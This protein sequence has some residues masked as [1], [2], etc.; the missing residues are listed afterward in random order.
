LTGVINRII[1][2]RLNKHSKIFVLINFKDKVGN[3]PKIIKRI[4][5]KNNQKLREILIIKSMIPFSEWEK[6]HDT[7]EHAFDSKIK[8]I[9]G[10][11]QTIKLIKFKGVS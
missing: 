3:Y 5:S 2:Y 1:N 6:H 4:K 11:K 8:L 9:K 7:F 10:N